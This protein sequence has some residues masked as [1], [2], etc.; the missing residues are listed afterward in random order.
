LGAGLG[1]FTRKSSRIEGSEEQ[2]DTVEYKS[3]TAERMRAW[4]RILRIHIDDAS[5]RNAAWRPD[6]S[7]D[8]EGAKIPTPEQLGVDGASE[9]VRCVRLVGSS[10]DGEGE[11]ASA[12]CAVPAEWSEASLGP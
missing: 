10:R 4:L 11:L 5:S 6:Q 1:R 12:A 2:G 9:W 3:T 7:A 8:G